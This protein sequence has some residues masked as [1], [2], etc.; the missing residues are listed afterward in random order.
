[1]ASDTAYDVVV[2]GGGPGGYV[3]A[4]RASQLGLKTA[5]VERDALGGV[6]LN[7]GCIPS[8]A[9]LHSAKLYTVMQKAKT[10]GFEV[11]GLSINWPRLIKRSRQVAG[12][13][14]KGV[15]GLFKKYG[16]THIAGEARIERPG[17]VQVGDHFIDAKH[18]I[19]ATGAR[20]RPLPGAPYDGDR[21]MSSKEAMVLTE[22]PESILIVGGGAIGCEFAYFF[23]AL[24][25]RVIQVELAD[26]LVPVED[27]DVSETLER[28][29]KRQGIEV[30][31]GKTA[32]DIVV[33][34]D[35]VT[36][37][38]VAADG[39]KA[40]VKVDRVLV[41][42]GVLCNSEDLGLKACGVE[43]DRGAIQVDGDLK[44]TCPGIYAVG[45]VTGPPML[46][47][48][49]SME[50]VHCAE[51]IAGQ[52]GKPVDYDNCPAATFCFPQIASVGLTEAQCVERGLDVKIGKFPFAASGKAL[53]EEA[54][55]GFVKVIHDAATGELI[56]C[57]IIGAGA[58]ELI[59]EVTLARTLEATEHEILGTI[60]THPTLAEAIHE[61]VGAAYGEGVNF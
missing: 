20:P 58:P 13:L 7:W 41:A 11:E 21:I 37:N 4:I 18:I 40:A 50:G 52:A 14:N 1:M 48:K 19:V 38:V 23:N 9:L 10:F 32:Q 28:A 59:A 39:S 55:D 61:A 43:V 17:R 24:G 54:K 33:E 25:T 47:H 42:I 12:R 53:A 8:K 30:H 45:D 51:R 6:C 56:G 34:A 27:A 57:H 2:I 26:R 22:Q 29:F 31:T 16:V 15:G 35:G 49:A 3:A 5:C 36:A 60:H 44:T 46:A